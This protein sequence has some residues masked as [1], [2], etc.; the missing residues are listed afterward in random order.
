[1]PFSETKTLIDQDSKIRIDVESMARIELSDIEYLLEKIKTESDNRLQRIMYESVIGKVSGVFQLAMRACKYLNQN[2]FDKEIKASNRKDSASG[3]GAVARFRDDLFHD[4]I[5]FIK[6]ETHYPFGKVSGRGFVAIRAC[7]GSNFRIEGVHN[8]D[9]STS[10]YA[11]TSEGVFEIQNPGSESEEWVM[12]EDFPSVS[13]VNYHDIEVIVHQ[14]LTE[15]K[16]IWN[17]LVAI[18]KHGDGETQYQYLNEGGSW[19]LLEKTEDKI[20]SYSAERKPINVEGSL[21]ITPP[22]SIRLDGSTLNYE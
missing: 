14:A 12:A 8:F 2:D 17:K 18:R 13:T 1:M 6:K 16:D 19:E 10:R 21:T 3:L 22:K 7:L 5:S 4:G 11:I 9:A 20:T 15:L